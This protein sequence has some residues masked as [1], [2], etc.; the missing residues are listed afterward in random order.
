MSSTGRRAFP[1]LILSDLR[2]G[3]RQVALRFLALAMVANVLCFMF[4]TLVAPGRTEIVSPSFADYIAAC[5]GGIET[6]LPR[7]ADSF[8]L[9]AGWLCLCGLMAYI[10]LDYPVRD[11]R[12]IGAHVVVA[13]GS[14]W[15]WWFSKCLWVFVAC[16][17][18]WLIVLASCALWATFAGSGLTSHGSLYLSPGVPSLLGFQAPFVSAGKANIAGFVAVLPVVLAAVCTMQL[19]LSI[20]FAPLVGFAAVIAVLLLSALHANGVLLGNYLMLA[21]SKLVS[22]AGVSCE[23]GL[24][25]AFAVIALFTVLG[26]IAYARRDIYGRG[27]DVS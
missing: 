4:Y 27:A 18:S 3:G 24:I 10:A 15:C 5:V 20:A 19:A 2:C 13:S 7:D 16:C 6:R 23:A 9:P 17:A 1:H 14:R 11:L 26:G 8:R 21:R 25:W 12:G 22:S